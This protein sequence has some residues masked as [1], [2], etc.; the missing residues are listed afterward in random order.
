MKNNIDLSH[1]PSIKVMTKDWMIMSQIFSKDLSK[2]L[3]S[4]LEAIKLAVV[5]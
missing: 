5:E 2:V 3:E 1:L 4:S